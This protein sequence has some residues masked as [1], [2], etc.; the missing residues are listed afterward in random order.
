MTQNIVEIPTVHELVTVQKFSELLDTM[1]DGLFPL[2]DLVVQM[3]NIELLADQVAKRAMTSALLHGMPFQG[4]VASSSP[5]PESWR[6]SLS[7]TGSSVELCR[8][9]RL[10]APPAQGGIQNTGHRD[11]PVP[12]RFG[13]HDGHRDGL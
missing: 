5:C 12:A 13:T 9:R 10:L 3:E 2:K 8:P 6:K 7:L 1:I 4:R 11:C